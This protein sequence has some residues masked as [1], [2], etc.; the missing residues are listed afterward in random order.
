MGSNIHSLL[1]SYILCPPK[2]EAAERGLR[3]RVLERECLRE[4]ELR[5]RAEK[6]L[7]ES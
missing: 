4:R 5:E 6:E 1:S 2:G 7:R 3:E